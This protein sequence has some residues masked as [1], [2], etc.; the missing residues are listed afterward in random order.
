MSGTAQFV[1][2][3]TVLVFV[4]M[5]GLS[6]EMNSMDEDL[7]AGK[8]NPTARK[9]AAQIDVEDKVPKTPAQQ[10]AEFTSRSRER[11]R[12]RERLFSETKTKADSGD[13][14]AQVDLGLM[15]LVEVYGRGRFGDLQE[16]GDRRKA[17]V[18]WFRKAAE[19]GD[20][21]A[22][23][24]LGMM[25]LSGSKDRAR[26]LVGSDEKEA[27]K[28]LRKAAEQ[29]FREAQA[30]LGLIYA[31]EG[32]EQDLEE[33][34]KWFRKAAEQEHFYGGYFLGQAYLNGDG[35]EEDL[36]ESF[37]WFLKSAEAGYPIAQ[38]Q[39]GLMYA[40]GRGVQKNNKKAVEW[41]EKASRQGLVKAQYEL[42]LRYANG[43]GVEQNLVMSYSWI[44]RASA[45]GDAKA[46]NFKETISK[47]LTPDQIAKAE[48]M[49][50]WDMGEASS[51]RESEYYITPEEYMMQRVQSFEG[52]FDSPNNMIGRHIHSN[53]RLLKEMGHFWEVKALA[54]QGNV[55]AQ[56]DLGVMYY[57]AQRQWVPPLGGEDNYK[58]AV[59]WYRKA[60]EKGYAPAQSRL[61]GM[62]NRGYGVP[63]DEKEAV[64]WYL[65]AAKQE[66]VSALVGLG[67]IYDE[68][69][70]YALFGKLVQRN[71][72]KSV[73]WFRKA[74]NL[75]G[76]S[77]QRILGDRYA[78]GRGVPKDNLT[79][80]MW[81]SLAVTNGHPYAFKEKGLLLKDMTP[82]QI[83]EAEVLIEKMLKKNPKLLNK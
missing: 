80:Y 47:K 29:G 11:A 15:Y 10:A 67:F 18:Q 74:A 21:F 51:Q 32:A 77:A 68:R 40:D 70:G 4:V 73:K 45:R 81:Y 60:A 65:K 23:Y 22:Q 17:A 41:Y 52:N 69:P 55:S 58:E 38:F 6:H 36:N 37:K 3:L 7:L 9:T 43:E 61:G 75:G 59:K 42:G 57:G 33:A 54:E 5:W 1:L 39:I 66:D 13:V 56:L 71:D 35:A 27:I 53:W 28:W 26:A 16:A 12:E 49:R 76:D 44:S 79:A 64:K 83:A 46:E 8:D 34:V 78:N 24:Q 72:K 31:F 63:R 50:H 48:K 14:R 19:Q 2:M 20:T 30:S 25:Y 62:Y 82:D